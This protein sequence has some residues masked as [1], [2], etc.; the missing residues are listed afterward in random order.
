MC[1]FECKLF[2][3]LIFHCSTLLCISWP[4]PCKISAKNNHVQLPLFFSAYG[5][6]LPEKQHTNQLYSVVS[7]YVWKVWSCWAKTYPLLSIL[8][9]AHRS[10]FKFTEK[11]TSEQNDYIHLT[12]ERCQNIKNTGGRIQAW[13]ALQALGFKLNPYVW[14]YLACHNNKRWS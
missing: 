8:S 14:V 12:L 7:S 3:E 11:P 9:N 13:L 1:F 10:K 2:L 4:F 5:G 6:Y